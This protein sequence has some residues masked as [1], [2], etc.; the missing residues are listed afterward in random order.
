[1]CGVPFGWDLNVNVNGC[2]GKRGVKIRNIRSRKN[3]KKSEF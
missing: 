3:K 2:T 1:M